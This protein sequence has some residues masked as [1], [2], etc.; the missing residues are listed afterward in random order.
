MMEQKALEKHIEIA[1]AAIVLKTA[2]KDF[3]TYDIIRQLYIDVYLEIY[4]NLDHFIDFMSLRN[5]NRIIS[6]R[7][8]DSCFYADLCSKHDWLNIEYNKLSEFINEIGYGTN[9]A[10]HVKR[11][12]IINGIELRLSHSIS[13]QLPDEERGLLM[14]LG[15]IHTNNVYIK[16][17]SII[18]GSKL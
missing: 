16:N 13:I 9:V 15:D 4:E 18:C 6:F 11:T 3:K 12:A 1:E 10:Y 7:H 5:I 8:D 2:L 14:M 17:E